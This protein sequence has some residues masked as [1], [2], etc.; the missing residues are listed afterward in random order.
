[1]L[2]GV[3]IAGLVLV[4]GG[5]LWAQCPQFCDDNTAL[6]DGA[7]G[8]VTTGADNTAVGFDALFSDTTGAFN[9]AVGYRALNLNTAS[10]NTAV[11][12][13]ALQGNTGGTDNTAVGQA[14]LANNNSGSANTVVGSSALIGGSGSYNTAIG[15]YAALL[16]NSGNN[17]TAVGSGALFTSTGSSNIAIGASAGV[18][19]TSG[20][21]NIDIGN[22]GVAGESGAI[23]IGSIGT[24]TAAF[25]AGVY[26]VPIGDGRD[27]GISPT[28]QLGVKPS[29]VRF[30][31]AIKPMDKLS[32]AILSLRPVTFRYKKGLDPKGASQFGLVAEE[33]A[34]VSPDLV[35]RDEQGKPYTVRYEAVNAMLLNEFLKEHRKVEE[36]GAEIAELK[37]A[38]AKQ[39][40]QIE[41]VSDQLRTQARAPL[42]VAND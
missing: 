22:A 9:T 41:M 24:Q 36:Q 28:G 23:R 25:F 29:S 11:G 14:A 37:A 27:I 20:N 8:S 19:L 34:K 16:N 15:F 26:G 39:A 32:E 5:Q 17:N 1:V 38:L 7:L 30:K 21:N 13:D 33:V 40:A 4:S 6:G 31:E 42:A 3:L 10:N 12:F 2:F 35:A 18:N